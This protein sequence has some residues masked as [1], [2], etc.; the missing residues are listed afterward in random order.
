LAR[1]SATVET[2]VADFDTLQISL[3]PGPNGNG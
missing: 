3:S 2:V 1:A